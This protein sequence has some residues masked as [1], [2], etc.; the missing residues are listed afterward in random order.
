MGGG[1]VVF[2]PFC[3]PSP[4]RLN[5]TEHDNGV[6]CSTHGIICILY[7]HGAFAAPTVADAVE[8]LRKYKR[9]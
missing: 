5:H 1:V 9:I 7:I 2:V 8:P 6:F 3:L 4:P